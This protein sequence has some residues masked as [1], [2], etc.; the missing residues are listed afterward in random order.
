MSGLIKLATCLEEREGSFWTIYDYEEHNL[1]GF[2]ERESENTHIRLF[3]PV[4]TLGNRIK[5]RQTLTVPHKLF[6][7]VGMADIRSLDELLTFTGQNSFLVRRPFGSIQ[8]NSEEVS[9]GAV[10][11]PNLDYAK[12]IS[13]VS[14]PS[15]SQ[16]VAEPYTDRRAAIEN[17][18]RNYG[19]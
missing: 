9:I 16:I 2:V 13:I 18:R 7:Y 14:R 19:N 6:A 5:L 11:F 1:Y 4:A 10:Y 3:S 12:V 8:R 15:E 17:T